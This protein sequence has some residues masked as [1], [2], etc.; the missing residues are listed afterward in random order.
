MKKYEELQKAWE[1]FSPLIEQEMKA[2]KDEHGETWNELIYESY[3]MICGDEDGN[4]RTAYDV[5][6]KL[7]A[8]RE[9]KDPRQ[10]AGAMVYILI[11]FAQVANYKEIK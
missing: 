1:D 8:Y 7:R 5:L 11:H 2:A 3:N 10:L 4:N 9:D 6:R